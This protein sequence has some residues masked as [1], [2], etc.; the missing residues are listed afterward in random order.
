NQTLFKK[1]AGFPKST[2]WIYG[3][4]DL[5]YTLDHSRKNFETFK[6]AGGKGEFVER[7]VRGKNNGHW[8]IAVPP[9]WEETVDQ[10]I[11]GIKN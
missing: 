10:Y 4:D 8:V 9:L 1:G 2:L 7:T 5:Y 6:K 3:E 11:A